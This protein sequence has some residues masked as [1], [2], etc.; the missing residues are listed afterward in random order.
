MKCLLSLALGLLFGLGLCLSGMT[1]PGKV[2]G[3]LDFA[4]S[5]DPSLAFVMGGAIG[6][7]VIAFAFA[8]RRPRALLGD[9]MHMP[10]ARAADAPLFIGSAVFGVGWGLS[11]ICPGP[12]V[13]NLGFLDFR[14]A[15]FVLAMLVGMA[16]ERLLLAVLHLRALKEADQ[17]G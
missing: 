7:G 13:V 12:A 14:A 2:H 11:G 9:L 8:G 1:Q 10:A 15:V 17:E 4:G 3:F 5:W 16:L 6:V